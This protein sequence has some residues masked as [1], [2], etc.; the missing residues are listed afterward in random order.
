LLTTTRCPF[1]DK[2]EKPKD[3]GGWG[4]GIKQKKREK[5]EEKEG[6][7]GSA[8][9]KIF[10]KG[11]KK[12]GGTKTQKSK[13]T[14]VF[15]TPTNIVLVCGQNE[16]ATTKLSKKKTE[17]RDGIWKWKKIRGSHRPFMKRKKKQD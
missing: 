8:M 9:G 15:P 17:K 11:K 13:A 16:Y 2:G 5:G 4:E 7:S 6:T 3:E 1:G 12:D 14:Q 10:E